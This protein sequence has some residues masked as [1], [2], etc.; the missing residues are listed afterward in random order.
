[1][2]LYGLGASTYALFG[3]SWGLGGVW[4]GL[5]WGSM[6]W[7]HLLTLYLVLL[8]GLGVYGWGWYGALW[9]GCIYLRFMWSLFGAWGC[10][11]GGGMGLHGL[12]ASEPPKYSKQW[13][14]IRSLHGDGIM[15]RT[16]VIAGSMPFR[17]AGNIDPNSYE[18]S[19]FCCGLAGVVTA[20]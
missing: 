10:M 1:M 6:V 15:A 17:L 3:P 18:L 4:L 12:G 20:S 2:G 11:A 8:G 7:V 13:P 16:K 19:F 5:V 14:G 9:L